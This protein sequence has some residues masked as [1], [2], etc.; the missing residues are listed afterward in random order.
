MT[1]DFYSFHST[2]EFVFSYYS[3]FLSYSLLALNGGPPLMIEKQQRRLRCLI[4]VIYVSG[5]MFYVFI[6][7]MT[8]DIFRELWDRKKVVKLNFA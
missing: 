8:T 6:I 4:R 7:C 1:S 2:V 5:N 3:H